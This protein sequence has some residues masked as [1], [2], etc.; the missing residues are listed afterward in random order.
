MDYQKRIKELST[1]YIDEIIAIRRHFHAHPELSFQETETATFVSQ[2]LTQMGIEHR[3][4]I[5]GNGILG[6]IKGDWGDGKTIALR[7][8]MDA[9][10]IQEENAFSFKSIH[11]GVMHACGHDIHTACLLGTAK[12]LNELKTDF[13]GTILLVF[14]PGEEKIPG[15]A[16][17]MMEDG[18][19][20]DYTPDYIIGQHVYPEFP[21]GEVGFRPGQYMASADEV[22]ITL[23]GKGGHAALPHST[24]DTVLMTS[25]TVVSL[26]QVVSRVI[27]TQVPAVLSFGNIVCKS[28]MNII[29]ETV[30]L[31]GTFR[32]MDENWRYKAH[33]KIRQITKSI[34]EG[35]GGSADVDIQIGFPSV[36]NDPELTVKLQ[37]KAKTVLG[38]EKVHDLDIRMTAEDFGWFAQK[39]P[40]CFYRLGVGHTDGTVSGG[41]HSPNFNANEAAIATGIELMSALALEA[42]K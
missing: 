27:P 32:I 40:A 30:R 6:I 33:D 35:M 29:P 4:G 8:D 41:L 28:A 21:A 1:Q 14:Q 9:L 10:P 16:K 3:I 23:K 39:Y 17:L 42:L 12:I 26:Q 20:D 18:L 38:K 19:F 13:S 7:G 15:G 2:K 36:F 37:D 25:Q 31:E 34:A 5:A 24:I 22:Y 11:Q